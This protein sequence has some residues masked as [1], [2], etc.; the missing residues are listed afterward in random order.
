[1]EI[2]V[3]IACPVVAYYSLIITRLTIHA[4]QH[5]LQHNIMLLEITAT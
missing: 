3:V 5:V 4:Y 2:V 1:M